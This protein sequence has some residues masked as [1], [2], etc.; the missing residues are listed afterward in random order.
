MVIAVT[1]TQLNIRTSPALV[2]EIDVIVE[3]GLYRTRTEAVNEALRLL[4]R[5]YRIMKISE[6]IE[7]MAESSG[8]D[9]G[10]T[11]ALLDSREEDGI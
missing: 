5:R 7:G 9:D 4:I 3:S 11:K 1:S 10:I 2:H 8:I 6:Q